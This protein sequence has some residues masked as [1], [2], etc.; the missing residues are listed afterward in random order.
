MSV[1]QPL[2]SFQPNACNMHTLARRRPNGAAWAIVSVAVAIVATLVAVPVGAVFVYAFSRGFDPV[3]RTLAR[4]D[5]HAPAAAA[6]R[7]L[8]SDADIAA[9]IVAAGGT[10]PLV[11][12][13][14]SPDVA[15]A[16]DCAGV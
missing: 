12:L 14:S 13:L 16:R 5:V 2:A 10:Q 15:I 9:L 11:E 1:A 3:L 8:A 6:L 4:A 7:G